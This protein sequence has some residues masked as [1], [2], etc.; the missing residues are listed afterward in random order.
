[1]RLLVMTSFPRRYKTFD[2]HT[3]QTTELHTFCSSTK[4][5]SCCYKMFPGDDSKNENNSAIK[6]AMLQMGKRRK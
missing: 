1:M 2:L 5:N 6:E 4:K 3:G